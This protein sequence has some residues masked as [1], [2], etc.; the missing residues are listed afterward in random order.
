MDE[1]KLK[2]A[3]TTSN[4]SSEKKTKVNEKNISEMSG[5]G[6]NQQALQE[7]KTSFKGGKT[8]EILMF[9]ENIS[10]TNR[11]NV[12]GQEHCLASQGGCLIQ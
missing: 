9:F 6:G 10:S 8:E 3:Y 4:I 11:A 7:R 5:P 2:N 12:R 1:R